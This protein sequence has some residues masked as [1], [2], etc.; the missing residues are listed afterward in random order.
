MCIYSLSLLI[1]SLCLVSPKSFSTRRFNR[2]HSLSLNQQ[3]AAPS[4]HHVVSYR[5][6]VF[7]ECCHDLSHFAVGAAYLISKG[8]DLSMSVHIWDTFVTFSVSFSFCHSKKLKVK[9]KLKL[10]CFTSFG[11]H[12]SVISIQ[13]AMI[14]GLWMR[15]KT[16]IFHHSRFYSVSLSLS[17]FLSCFVRC[18]R[19]LSI[20]PIRSREEEEEE[21]NWRNV[22]KSLV[23]FILRSGAISTF[24]PSLCDEEIKHFPTSDKHGTLRDQ[25]ADDEFLRSQKTKRMLKSWNCLMV[26]VNITWTQLAEEWIK[27]SFRV[28]KCL[29]DL[30]FTCELKTKR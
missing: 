10:F 13:R 6:L 15:I 19:C 21:K 8:S 1:N 4:P 2:N 22:W 9:Y 28:G 16:P 24:F 14:T 11:K 30:L 18:R 26:N 29:L 23:F 17:L 20:I 5:K 7:F 27:L 12:L 3:Y 25:Q